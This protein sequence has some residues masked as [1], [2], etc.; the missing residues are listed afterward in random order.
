MIYSLSLRDAGLILGIVLVVG[1][2]LALLHAGG[3]RRLLQR[4]PRSKPVGVALLTVNLVWAWRLVSTMD[5]GEFTPWRSTILTAL[6]VLYVLAIFFVDE[7]LPVRALGLFFLLAAE[8]LLEA[9]F[10]R[11]EVSR[12]LVT[13][14]AYVWLTLGLFWVGM[15]YLLRDQIAW[16]SKN[17]TRWRLAALG[18]VAYGAALLV[19]ALT[20]YGA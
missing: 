4:F 13:V 17:D 8:P 5:L 3:A 16:V 12:L 20:L 1:H 6:V 7:F 14:L 15:P 19:C 18:G 10:L 9:A 2:L 11:P